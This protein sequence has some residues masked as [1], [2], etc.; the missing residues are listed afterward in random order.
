[1]TNRLED[2]KRRLRLRGPHF[3]YMGSVGGV[4]WLVKE[5]EGERE[6][7]ADLSAAHRESEE[8]IDELEDRL[9]H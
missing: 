2:I 6:A 3:M 4:E 9:K 8:Y 1:M 5:L 7:Y